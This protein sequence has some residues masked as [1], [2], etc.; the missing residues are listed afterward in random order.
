M[1]KARGHPAGLPPLVSARFQVLFH[2]AHRGAC[3]RSVALLVH[4]RS[5]RS[6]QPWRV[7]PPY[8]T[9]VSR[10]RDYS[11][12]RRFPVTGLSP[13]SAWHSGP[14]IRTSGLPP[15]P[16]DSRLRIPSGVGCPNR[17]PSDHSLFPSPPKIF[18]GSHVLHRLPTP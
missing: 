12:A 9:R 15:P 5:S 10:D 8:S 3:H 1:Q 4:Y 6:I 7:D 17:A 2:S 14:F 13:S 18:A 16:L 11:R